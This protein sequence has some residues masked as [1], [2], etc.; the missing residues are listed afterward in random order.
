VSEPF[1]YKNAAV[2]LLRDKSTGDLYINMD[3]KGIVRRVDTSVIE[4]QDYL[5]MFRKKMNKSIKSMIIESRI[6]KIEKIVSR[7]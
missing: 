4:I 1:Y 5:P 6:K 3:Y 2:S 7:I